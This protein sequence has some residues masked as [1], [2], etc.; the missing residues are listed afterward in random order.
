MTSGPAET[1]KNANTSNTG[2][3]SADRI[4]DRSGNCPLLWP[5]ASVLL[6]LIETGEID[7]ESCDRPSPPKSPKRLQASRQIC[8]EAACRVV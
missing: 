6:I 3:S 4:P 7:C 5:S 1:D 2:L 8:E